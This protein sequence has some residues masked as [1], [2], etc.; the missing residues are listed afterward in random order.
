MK[1]KM[2]TQE[3]VEILEKHLKRKTVKEIAKD[4]GRTEYSVF[5]KLTMIREKQIEKLNMEVS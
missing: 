2:W 4:I 3:E 5:S 1:L